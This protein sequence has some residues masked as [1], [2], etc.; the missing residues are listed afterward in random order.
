MMV[1][2]PLPAPDRSNGYL[3]H[4]VLSA[5]ADVPTFEAGL[6]RLK[7]LNDQSGGDLPPPPWAEFRRDERVPRCDFGAAA[8]EPSD[9]PRCFEAALQ[10]DVRK[11][12]DAHAVLLARYRAMREKPRFVALF[13]PKSPEDRLP[14]YPEMLEAQRMA[15][16]AAALRFQRGDRAGA[17]SEVERD[18]AFYRR[19][20][21]DA[22]MLIDKMIAFAALDREALFVAELARHTPR[23]E[24]AL[25]RRLESV[26]APLSQAELDVVPSLRREFASTA[27]WGSTRDHARLSD[28]MW[29][30]LAAYTEKT[31]PWWQ[32]A[33]PYFYRPHQ[34]VNWFAASC[35]L[36][37]A[38]AERPS[39]EFFDALGT[40]RDQAAS[41]DPGPIYSLV[42]NPAGWRHPLIGPCKYADYVARA[43]GRA[44]VQ[45]LAHLIVKLRVSGISKPEEIAKALAGPLGKAHADPFSGEPM[46]F[47]PANA[48]IGFDALNQHLSGAAR[49]LRARYGRVALRP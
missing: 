49:P 37:L 13:A 36:F 20:A 4:L 27:R 44:G 38:V 26:V 24:A 41:L 7:A 43:H 8:G 32:P 12:V 14:A 15:L 23:S 22:T 18:A 47:D 17:I 6:E 39:T 33:A 2:A 35:R 28:T 29:E 21:R 42:V 40:A 30:G 5:P 1:V 46:R 25:W 19:M 3:D 9:G 16:L 11:A 48:T 34:T 31:R 45:T 10:P